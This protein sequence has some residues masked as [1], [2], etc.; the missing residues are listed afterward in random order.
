MVDVRAVTAEE[1]PEFV[2]ALNAAFSATAADD[3]LGD[4][5]RLGWPLERSVGAF[6][7]GRIVGSAGAYPF[8]MTLP[9]LTSVP[10]AGV[11]WVGVMPTHRRRGVLTSLMR[12]QV[13]EVHERGESLAVLLASES[14]IYGRFGYGLSTLQAEY[15]LPRHHRALARLHEPAGRVVLVDED[16]AKKSLPD[17]HEK[18]R[19]TQPGDLSRTEGWWSSW[20]R[21]GKRSG[22]TGPRFIALYE[23]AGSGAVEGYVVYRVG[24]GGTGPGNAEWT[25]MV[26]GLGALTHDAYVSL[27]MY[28][29]DID[30][31]VKTTTTS[32]PLDEPLRWLLADPRKLEATS[33]KDFLWTRVVDVGAAL[34]ARRYAVDDRL[35]LDVRD[36]FCPWNESRWLVEGGPD[37]ATCSRTSDEADLVLGANDLG[38]IFLGGTRASSLAAVGRIAAAREEA[39]GRADRFFATS[40]APYCQTFF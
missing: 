14:I 35:V 15:E 1:H 7:D 29:T 10:T 32:R 40:P 16:E 9:G 8:E 28:V 12:H 2:R 6:V 21:G 25:S 24:T 5:E 3:D 19:R 36:E 37:G 18:V 33:V 17:I 26:Q 30:L 27:W 20:F 11:T 23:G 34:S 39:I 38:A 22:N 13:D 4:V 31:T